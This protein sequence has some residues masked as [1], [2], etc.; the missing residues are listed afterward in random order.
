MHR[1]LYYHLNLYGFL[2][3]TQFGFRKGHSM[4][5]AVHHFTDFVNSTLEPGEL[6]L[7]IFIDFSKAFDT[8]VFKILLSR[9]RC[10]GVQDVPLNWFESYLG[11]RTLR[12]NVDCCKSRS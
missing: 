2:A 8:V 4:I 6:V 3:E 12:G 9:L 10:L 5:H 7:S 1:R 11:G